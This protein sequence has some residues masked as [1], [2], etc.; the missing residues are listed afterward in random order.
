MEQAKAEQ[1][2]IEEGE[3]DIKQKLRAASSAA[4]EA[5]MLAEEAEKEA[6]MIESMQQQQQQD[7]EQVHHASKAPHAYKFIQI[8]RY[9]FTTD[10]AIEDQV[11]VDEQND[12]QQQI[13]L[14]DQ[15]H[16]EN[17]FDWKGALNKA[18][19]AVH[20]LTK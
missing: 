10:L 15:D 11:E 7:H 13:D 4:N 1:A 5:E 2:A 19:A 3:V 16:E 8:P 18:K 20:R 6:E 14:M 12:E 9:A 17:D